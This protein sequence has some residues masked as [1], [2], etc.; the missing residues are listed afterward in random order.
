VA[1]VKQLGPLAWPANWHE[2]G[3]RLEALQSIVNEHKE[4]MEVQS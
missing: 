2:D 1:A 3:D 4:A